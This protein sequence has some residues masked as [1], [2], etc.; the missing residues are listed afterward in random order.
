MSS[1]WAPVLGVAGTA[2][3]LAGSV[4]TLLGLVSAA[5]D[6]RSKVIAIVS[7]LWSSKEANRALTLS[8]LNTGKAL[9]ADGIRALRGLVVLAVGYL[10]SL[11]SGV[12]AT[13][14]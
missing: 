3:Q 12:W 14:A 5:G 4:M 1:F 2:L 7:S 6:M 9:T 11:V 8:T 13:F 10:L